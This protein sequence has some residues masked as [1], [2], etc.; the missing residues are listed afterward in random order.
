MFYTIYKT[1]N[2]TNGKYYIGKHITKDLNDDYLGSGE[3]LQYAL[4]KYGQENFIKQ[5]LHIFDCEWKMDLAE[6]ILV[7]VDRETNYNIAKGG[8][9]GRIVLIKGHELYDQ[10]CASISA[11]KKKAMQK[12]TPEQRSQKFG[13]GDFHLGRKRS[14]ETIIKMQEAAKLRKRYTCEHCN[15]E[16]S[17]LNYKKWHG[18][19]CKK[20]L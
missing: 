10:T 3:R 12:L 6:R 9:G 2:L 4:K 15:L 7:V 13:L 5:I 8:Q 11:G 19:K 1:I 14:L 20:K 17:R 16:I 18:E